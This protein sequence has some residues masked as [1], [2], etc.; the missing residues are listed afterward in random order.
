MATSSIKAS[1]K[2]A[3]KTRPASSSV[4]EVGTAVTVEADTVEITAGTVEVKTDESSAEG[5]DAVTETNEGNATGNGTVDGSPAGTFSWDSLPAPKIAVY[6]RGIPRK[7]LEEITPTF[8]KSCVATAYEATTKAPRDS[9]DREVPVYLVQQCPT[10]KRAEEFVQL[11][12]K[13][14]NFKELTFR[15]GVNPARKTEVRFAIKS[16]ETRK[17]VT[18]SAEPVAESA[19]TGSGDS[20]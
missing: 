15:G 19:S 14:A 11:C 18:K 12:R 9:K 6:S 20:K 5:T 1:L 10:P 16:K 3:A 7:D 2:K 13:Y 8:I 4:E 17:R